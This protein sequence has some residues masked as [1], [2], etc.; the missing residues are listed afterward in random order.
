VNV[1]W[2]RKIRFGSRTLRALPIATALV[3][4][5]TLALWW[6]SPP[7]TAAPR[8]PGTDGRVAAGGVA[9]GTNALAAGQVSRGTGVPATD[10]NAWP[11]FR[12]PHRDG[13]AQANV[14]PAR[15]WGKTGPRE[16]WNIECGEGY[17]G[18][19]IAGGC[20]FLIDYDATKKQNALRCLS[21]AD[22]REIWRYAYPLALKRDHGMTRT[23]PGVSGDCVVAIDPKCNVLCV[24]A[25][26]G[27]LRWGL[28]MVREFGATVPP[29]Y[30]GQCPLID[31]NVVVLAPGGP[32]ALF[33]A[34]DLASGREL[35]RTPNPRGWKMTHS[36]VMSMEFEGKRQYLYCASGGVASAFAG[37]GAPAWDYPDWKVNFAT[38]PSPLVLS[39]NRIFLSGGYNAGSAM[40]QLTNSANGI[41]PVTL[42][43][44]KAEVFGA[45]QQTPIDFDGHIYGVRANG[46]F[47]C[48]SYDGSVR[49]SS[50]PGK[51]FGLGPFLGATNV[52][53]VM[54]DSGTLT[55]IEATPERYHPLA[56]AR[57]LKGR[58][59]WGPMAFANGRLLVRDFTRLACLDVSAASGDSLS[60]ASR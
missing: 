60:T 29:W 18:P 48:L 27:A 32:K 11:Q 25:K 52:I 50:P 35:W 4:A 39:G 15:D 53:Y 46:Q 41:V 34:V 16:V 59:S 2:L 44:L 21:L 24:D 38:V 23:V 20:V 14:V 45:T 9:G 17:A 1:N 51:D 13:I 49:W 55:L 12:G 31:G 26:T 40:L 28:D 6:F 57:V 36:S 5:G 19:A 37:D 8:L 33:V 3:A 54:N 56:E 47:V 58:E 7:P 42:F 43:R 30:T 10:T 22:G